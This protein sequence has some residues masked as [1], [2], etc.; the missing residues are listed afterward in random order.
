MERWKDENGGET[1]SI[2][3]PM[4]R[5][6][7]RLAWSLPVLVSLS[8]IL[9][10]PYIRHY[11]AGYNAVQLWKGGRTPAS[12]YLWIYAGLLFPVASRMAIEALDRATDG[13]LQSAAA[14]GAGVGG[15]LLTAGLASLGIQVAVVTVPMLVLAAVLFFSPER[16]AATGRAQ[17]GD[18]RLL[19]LLVAGTMAL[20]LAVEIVVLEGDIGRMNTV[21]KFY[22]QVWMLLAVAAAVSV[23]WLWERFRKSEGAWPRVWWGAMVVLLLG[24]LLFL[25]MGVGARATDRMAPE[26]GLTLNGM[27]F[28]EDAVIH[29]GPEGDMEEIAL[30][31]DYN[32]IRWMQE[33]VDGSPVIL[34]GLGRRE[35]L[36]ANRVS[37][38]TGLPAVAGWRWHEVQ[39]R[40]G[41]GGDLVT[42]RRSDVDRFYQTDSIAEA[43]EILERHDVRY[44]YVGGYERAYY[45]P[46]G[47]NKFDR[48]AEQGALR[49]V[50]DADG[51][52]I[53][54]VVW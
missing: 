54:E 3:T 33:N 12:I 37:I 34:E 31:G 46:G 36:W 1:G 40:V 30:S 6:A 5:F 51:V 50:Y 45:A 32:A 39:Q 25:P 24:G 41:V 27:A 49:T 13:R 10:L 7:R 52:T 38:Y 43:E 22:L 11:V 29:D 4:L 47:L 16:S 48:M 21:F 19:W 15:L 14:I 44:V 8:V 42:W 2:G 18:E 20:S 28:M 9:Y 23:A 17:G 35:Y 26:T 53:Y